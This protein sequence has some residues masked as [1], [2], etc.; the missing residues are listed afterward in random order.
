[1]NDVLII[2]QGEITVSFVDQQDLDSDRG[3]NKKL[4][5]VLSHAVVSIFA[6]KSEPSSAILTHDNNYFPLGMYLL[7]VPEGFGS[8]IYWITSIDNRYNLSGFKEF[9]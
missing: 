6:Y 9:F 8:F 2:P 3:P 1:M 7:K 5:M 4:L